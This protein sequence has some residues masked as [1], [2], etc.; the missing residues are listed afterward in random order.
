MDV[1]VDSADPPVC[2]ALGKFGVDTLPPPMGIGAGE[3][4]YEGRRLRFDPPGTDSVAEGVLGAA[5]IEIDADR[6]SLPEEEADP[7][8]PR[9]KAIKIFSFPNASSSLA[10]SS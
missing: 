9:R 6:G 2:G 4:E 10:F 7:G 5:V 8:S 1:R 3:A